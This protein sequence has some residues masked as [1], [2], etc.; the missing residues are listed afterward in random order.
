ML[1]E[2]VVRCGEDAEA[3]HGLCVLFHLFVI[4]RGALLGGDGGC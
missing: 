3:V 2:R 1:H 4:F